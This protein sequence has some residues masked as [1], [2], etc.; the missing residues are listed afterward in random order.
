MSAGCDMANGYTHDSQCFVYQGPDVSHQ[1]ES[2]CINCN[3]R[4]GNPSLNRVVISNVTNSLAPVT[5]SSTGYAGAGYAHQGWITADHRYYLLDDELDEQN[6]GG[7]T[8]TYIWD[9]L[10]LDAPQL[11]GVHLGPTA[12]IDHNQYIRGNFSYQSNYRA[13]LRI[14]ETQ[15]I[16]GGLLSEVGFFDVY[17]ANDNPSFNGTWANYPFFP[18]G[19]VVVTTI[20]S[21][22]F[23][24]FFVLRPLFADLAVTVTDSPD[25]VVSGQNV[26][27][28]FSIRNQ[29]P[30]YSS[31]TT[32]TD[33]LPPS[34]TFVSATSSQGTCSGT[35]AI[36]CNLGT[37]QPD[38]VATVTV[39]AQ[40][41]AP[42][43]ITNGATAAADET[44]TRTADNM[45][46]A[47]TTVTSSVQAHPGKR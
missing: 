7:N 3:G 46:S 33:T 21:T 29:G 2:L 18:S 32:L 30:T 34:L 16:A 38:A 28:T 47:Q 35:T 12:A 11:I 45:G 5:I 19:N 22:G 1:G 15:N 8:K 36:T 42:G 6:S 31:N 25:P 26:T 20:E 17:P 43:M 13:G 14:L 41:G 23:G 10:D 9:L 40:A 44:D 24:G 37:V 27:Y 4:Q 39:V